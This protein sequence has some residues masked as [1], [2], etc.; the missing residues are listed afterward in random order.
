MRSLG[1]LVTL[2]LLVPAGVQGEDGQVTIH[3][4]TGVALT[5]RRPSGGS[6]S[7]ILIRA[8]SDGQEVPAQRLCRAFPG[9]SPEAAG[10]LAYTFPE[11]GTATFQF[12]ERG[13]DSSTELV[14]WHE[15]PERGVVFKGTVIY[16]VRYLTGADGSLL[17]EGRLDLP[18]GPT[19]RTR[20]LP[21][22]RDIEVLSGSE[23]AL[24]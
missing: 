3:N 6:G 24:H 9:Q 1:G 7:A 21:R 12:E 17:A 19:P 15:A 10:P 2:L 14:F 11:G 22:N 20:C 23:L 5:V 18:K 13:R 16:S 8:A 4:R